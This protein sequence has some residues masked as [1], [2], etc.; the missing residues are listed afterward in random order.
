M[1][2]PAI[3]RAD[4][5]RSQ[6]RPS[7]VPPRQ[8]LSLKKQKKWRVSGSEVPTAKESG[9]SVVKRPARE[10]GPGRV[11]GDPRLSAGTPSR[12]L[13]LATPGRPSATRAGWFAIDWRI[14]NRPDLHS[15]LFEG[16]RKTSKSPRIFPWYQ[17]SSI[18]HLGATY[19]RWHAVVNTCH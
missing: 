14:S 6:L 12:L 3:D 5:G 16:I 18:K 10:P 17:S 19:S 7:T 13:G 15:F 9:G 4:P 8:G 2:C 11:S 1:L